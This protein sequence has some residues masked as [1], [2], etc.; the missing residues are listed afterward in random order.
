MLKSCGLNQNVDFFSM[1]I[2]LELEKNIGGVNVA[3]TYFYK[4]ILE[5]VWN[6]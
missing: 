2:A 1:F 6:D 4:Q 5:E 3:G